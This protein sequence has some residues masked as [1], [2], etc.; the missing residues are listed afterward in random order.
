MNRTALKSELVINKCQYGCKKFAS[1]V[2]Q[3][4]KG[5]VYVIVEQ[6]VYGKPLHLPTVNLKLL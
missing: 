3:V 6:V 1:L 2:G 4:D 5:K